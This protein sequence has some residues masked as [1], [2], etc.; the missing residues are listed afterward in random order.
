M[1]SVRIWVG[2]VVG[3][4]VG[5]GVGWGVF[6]DGTR[7]KVMMTILKTIW[8]TTWRIPFVFYC[9]KKRKMSAPVSLK[10][11]TVYLINLDRRPD[12]LS[13]AL[14][15]LRGAGFS[16]IERQSAVDGKQIDSEQIRRLVTPSAYKSLGKIRARDEDLGSVGAIGCAMSHYI[17]W[18]KV[19]QS[20]QPAIVTEDDL[21]LLDNLDIF[22][23]VR[24][25]KKMSDYDLV[26]LGYLSLREP[27]SSNNG[28][29]GV[30]P[31]KGMM[32]GM[33]F[34][35]ITPRAAELLISNFFPIEYQV[36]SYIGFE[37]KKNNG[38]N[39]LRVGYH[40]P[41]LSWQTVGITDIQTPCNVGMGFDN[42]TFI[43]FIVV[44]LLCA[45]MLICAFYFYHR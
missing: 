31:Y 28:L 30:Y 27:H 32:F 21:T 35:Y 22:E 23:V 38:N 37:I 20:N 7:L 15:T 16:K 44:L 29:A 14:Q 4:V 33:H 42:V 45:I 36:D 24:D 43:V 5:V 2:V 19:L 1:K 34:Y 25:Y 8:M 17:V 9:I 3:I 10:D 11:L 6:V 39:N 12:R 40:Y 13:S 41:N 26:W 18:T